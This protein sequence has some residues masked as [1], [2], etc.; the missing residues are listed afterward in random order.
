[1][2]DCIICAPISMITLG[3]A[4]FGSICRIWYCETR[5]WW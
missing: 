2:L 1:M 4:C 3:F 5:E